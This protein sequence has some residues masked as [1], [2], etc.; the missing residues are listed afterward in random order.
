MKHNEQI[1]ILIP[2]YNE[3]NTIANVISDY[4]KILPH[5]KIYVFDN[6]SSDNTI[7]IAK[8]NGAIVKQEKK[9]GKGHVVRK[10]FSNI[11]ADIYL[12]VDGDDTYDAASAIKLIQTLKNNNL[13]MVV[14]SRYAISPQSYRIG[15]KLGNK[16]FNTIVSWLF[17]N[18]FK[19]I[20]SGY[21][22]FS[23][24]FIKSFPCFAGGFEIEAEMSIY[25]LEMNL[26]VDE[27]ETPYK[28][29]PLGSS[30]KLNT[31]QDGCKI[32]LMI[33]KL[34]KQIKPLIFFSVWA[35]FFSSCAIILFIPILFEY[36]N[37]GLVPRLPTAIL[38]TSLMIISFM[39]LF[40][41]IILES[42]AHAR[43][44][45]NWLCYLTHKNS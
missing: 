15:H 21:R 16:L 43:R 32:L 19:D 33:L 45:N 12:L 29:R 18:Q 1:A 6:N 36:I 8:Q 9:Q 5:A 10:M 31:I 41:G 13:D 34:F 30:S 7:E 11:E 44:H 35:I 14:G 27:V 40:S 39:C 26:A 23:K 28:N 38:S 42:V 24:K 3:E 22:V 20:F 25:A 4:K 2:C 17:G 37:T